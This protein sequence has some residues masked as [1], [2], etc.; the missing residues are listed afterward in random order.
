MANKKIAELIAGALRNGVTHPGRNGGDPMP[1]VIPMFRTAGMPQ[2]M[3]ELVDETTTL[4]GEAIVHLIETDGESEIV[5]KDQA[6]Q[7]RIAESDAAVRNVSVHC[8]C[9][10]DRSNPLAVLTITNSPYVVIDGK[11]LIKGLAA[12]SPDHPHPRITNQPPVDVEVDT[13]E[14]EGP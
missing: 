14:I 6:T 2:E 8:R 1:I 12:R 7:L 9:D 13:K 5:S 4:L 3:T 10:S 11:Q